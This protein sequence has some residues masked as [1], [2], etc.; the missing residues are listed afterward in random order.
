MQ[1]FFHTAMSKYS[2]PPSLTFLCRSFGLDIKGSCGSMSVPTFFRFASGRPISRFLSSVSF[3][4]FSCRLLRPISNSLSFALSRNSGFLGS[5]PSVCPAP[6]NGIN[7]GVTGTAALDDPGSFFFERGA[8]IIFNLS[9]LT[10]GAEPA[11]SFRA[12]LL[13]FCSFLAIKR[14]SFLSAAP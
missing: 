13:S 5:G 1:T 9:F 12:C 6:V 7:L 4:R 2:A 3:I 8:S 14:S 10:D 11:A